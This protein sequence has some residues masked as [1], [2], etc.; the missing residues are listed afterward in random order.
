V[1]IS[2]SN[3][4]RSGVPDDRPA[5]IIKLS[6]GEA[7]D[8]D[9]FFGFNDLAVGKG[10]DAPP[11]DQAGAKG[12][13]SPIDADGGAMM[14]QLAA[15]RSSEAGQYCSQFKIG[16]CHFQFRPLGVETGQYPR[17]E[18]ERA[19]KPVRFENLLAKFRSGSKS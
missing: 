3:G 9:H 6:H 5:Q 15:T 1:L 13:Q 17:Q 10:H 14:R 8:F 4:H 16:H 7:F 2:H 11:V 18:C 19:K 12:S